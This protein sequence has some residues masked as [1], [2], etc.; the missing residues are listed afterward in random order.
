MTKSE[1]VT[2]ATL[3]DTITYCITW[4]N[5]SGGPIDINIWDTV[6]ITMAY[7]SCWAA[8]G[9]LTSCNYSPRLAYFTVGTGVAAG[10][11][12]QVCFRAVVTGYPWTPGFDTAGWLAWLARDEDLDPASP[13]FNPLG[14]RL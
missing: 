9:S 4:T 2:S 14:E 1:N 6:P 5:N 11:S 7:L 8:S 3:G 13:G 10:A 12:G